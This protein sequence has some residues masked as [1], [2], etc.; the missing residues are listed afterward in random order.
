MSI[1]HRL[2]GKRKSE[3]SSFEC[4]KFPTRGIDDPRVKAAFDELWQRAMVRGSMTGRLGLTDEEAMKYLCDQVLPE[5]CER[6]YGG[7]TQ[8][9]LRQLVLRK[10]SR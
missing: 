4:I 7:F 9:A 6:F 5:M 10:Y 3:S 1:W 8:E 2:F